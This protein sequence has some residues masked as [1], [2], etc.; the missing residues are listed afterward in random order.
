MR[1]RKKSKQNKKV[2]KKERNKMNNCRI[3][4]KKKRYVKNILKVT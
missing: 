1:W 2:P 4:M 3:N